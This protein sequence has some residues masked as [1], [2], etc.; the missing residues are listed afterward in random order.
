MCSEKSSEKKIS[1]KK[2]ITHG[3]M[4][5]GNNTQVSK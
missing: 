4:P 5:M 1:A 2:I 3:K